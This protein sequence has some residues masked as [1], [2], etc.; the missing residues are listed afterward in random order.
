MQIKTKKSKIS[1]IPVVEEFRIEQC[2]GASFLS[3]V[4]RIGL[5]SEVPHFGA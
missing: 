1:L 4:D 3:K 5:I 2:G